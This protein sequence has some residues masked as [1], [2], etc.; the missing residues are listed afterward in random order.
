MGGNLWDTLCSLINVIRNA[1]INWWRRIKIGDTHFCWGFLA[2][3]GWLLELLNAS[4]EVVLG[5]PL[6]KDLGGSSSENRKS[7]APVHDWT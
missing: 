4:V 1:A 3:E 7:P 6:G 5:G 2:W